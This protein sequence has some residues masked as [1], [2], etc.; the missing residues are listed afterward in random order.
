MRNLE[1]NH[2]VKGNQIH[3]ASDECDLFLGNGK[4]IENLG[5]QKL[6]KNHEKYQSHARFLFLRIG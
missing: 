4:K 3:F 6:L 5:V 2:I 1:N